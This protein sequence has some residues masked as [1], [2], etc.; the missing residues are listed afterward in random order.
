[1]SQVFFA[2]ASD[3]GTGR[4]RPYQH[5]KKT[6]LTP[7]KVDDYREDI[8]DKYE[9]EI[10]VWGTVEGN[11]VH[12]KNIRVGDYL[13]FYTGGKSD[14]Y[15]YAAEVLG[16]DNNVSLARRLWP[17]YHTDTQG[18]Y[19][20]GGDPWKYIIYLDELIKIRVQKDEMSDILDQKSGKTQKFQRKSDEKQRLIRRKYGSIDNFIESIC[21]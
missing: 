8:P 15:E 21:V 9:G 2:P 20:T 10:R 16:K 19:D 18:K 14:Q 1:M 4:D 3:Q 7:V 13:I 5:L 17:D 12:W 11:R 6:V